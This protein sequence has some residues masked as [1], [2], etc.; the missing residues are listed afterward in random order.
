MDFLSSHANWLPAACSAGTFGYA[1]GGLSK[2]HF[3]IEA[4]VLLQGE[5]TL[6]KSPSIKAAPLVEASTPV[7]GLGLTP[8]E[9]FLF[10]H[11][12]GGNNGPVIAVERSNW[13]LNDGGISLGWFLGKDGTVTGTNMAGGAGVGGY[14][15]FTNAAICLEKSSPSATR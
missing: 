8:D 15:T 10:L 2:K 11:K 6:G 4:G 3:G 9:A 14:V 7:F 12:P 13:G 5:K 1:T